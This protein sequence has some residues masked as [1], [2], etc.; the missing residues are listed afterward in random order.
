[1]DYSRYSPDMTYAD[2]GHPVFDCDFHLYEGADAFTRHLPEKYKGLVRLANVD[3]RTKMIIRG[4]VSDYIPNPTFEVVAEP[5]SA[6][7][8]FSGR[9]TEGKS[10][11]EIS[12]ET[13]VP[14]N[15]IGPLLSRARSKM[16][17]AGADPA[18]I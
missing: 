18:A 6:A 1:M 16:R 11:R 13:G 4:R 12:Q 2:F 15:T 5:G 10:Y 8:Y 17:Q 9:N 14:E 7:E 3:G